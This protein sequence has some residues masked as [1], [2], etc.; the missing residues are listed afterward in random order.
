MLGILTAVLLIVPAAYPQD[1]AP[2]KERQTKSAL[3]QTKK[4]QDRNAEMIR[5]LL[6]ERHEMLSKLLNQ[7]MAQYNAGT[8]N[9]G[10][11]HVAMKELIKSAAELD[12]S[13]E[14]RLAALKE[15]LKLANQI[16]KL[17]EAR[18]KVGVAHSTDLLEARVMQLN[19]RIEVLREE[20]KSQ[21]RK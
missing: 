15:D 8:T 1:D 5:A 3:R 18:V 11:V 2:K 16:V 21:P 12:G 13:P 20:G 17:T 4:V 7:L 10:R 6:E 9:F 19:A 14:K